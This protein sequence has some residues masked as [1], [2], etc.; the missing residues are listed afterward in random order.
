M[1]P[2]SLNF[3]KPLDPKRRKFFDEHLPLARKIAARFV[4]RHRYLATIDDATQIAREGV[5]KAARLVRDIETL[6]FAENYVA[7]HIWRALNAAYFHPSGK[8]QTTR[9]SEI[10][11]STPAA[12][13]ETD[14]DHTVLDFAADQVAAREIA[15][16][17]GNDRLASRLADLRWAITKLPGLDERTRRALRLRFVMG[18]DQDAAAARMNLSGDK[19]KVL[20]RDGVRKL[21]AHFADLGALPINAPLPNHG[22]EPGRNQ[23][24]AA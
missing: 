7:K 24:R 16:D 15:S 19:V 1:R 21:R 4:S 12:A 8:A 18:L 6:D 11:G 9:D 14:P 17:P 20:V 2:P 10:Q 3:G 13:K 5:W 22:N 23:H